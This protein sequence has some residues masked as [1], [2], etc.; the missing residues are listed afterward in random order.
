MRYQDFQFV[1]PNIQQ[2]VIGTQGEVARFIPYRMDTT[3]ESILQELRRQPH[4][5]QLTAHLDRGRQLYL[6]EGERPE[7]L[8]LA[9]EYIASYHR[10]A[11]TLSCH[12]DTGSDCED[13]DIEEDWQDGD[14]NFRDFDFSKSIPLLTLQQLQSFYSPDEGFGFG[15]QMYRPDMTPQK[16]PWWTLSQDSPLI[17]SLIDPDQEGIFFSSNLSPLPRMLRSVGERPL[18]IV[19]TVQTQTNS[20]LDSDMDWTSAFDGM[21]M[22]DVSFELETDCIRLESPD[23]ESRYKQD[24]LRQLA[25]ERKAPLVRGASALKILSLVEEHRGDM[26]NRTISKA[27]SNALLRR[28]AAGP[29]R[30]RDFAYLSSVFPRRQAQTA[31]EE[32]PSA[33]VGQEDIRRKLERVAD[34]MVFQKRR[35]ALGLPCSPI[36]YTF[37]F[38]GAPGTGKTSWAVWLTKEMTRRGLLRSSSFISINAAELKA[39]YVGHTTGKVKALFQQYNAIL[40]DEAYSLSEGDD[41]F[42]REALAQ[43]CIELEEHAEDRLVIFAGYGGSSDPADNRMLHFLQSNPGINSRVSFKVHFPSLQSEE[44]VLVLRSMLEREHYTLPEDFPALAEGFFQQRMGRRAFG[45][46]RE[47]RNLADRI[48]LQLAARLGDCSECGGE[49]LSGIQSQDIQRAAAEILEEYRLLEENGERRIG[50]LSPA[51]L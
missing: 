39:K 45:S 29:L 41:A 3:P 18:I 38:L 9:A 30:E 25:R 44:L 20:S 1:L 33:L 11:D 36:H 13:P 48:K 26:D 46:C 16:R 22:D 37:A 35:R 31:Q 50:F 21:S 43:L 28:K 40:L 24:I 23:Q 42:S 5:A 47:A 6:L 2:T 10:L 17:I 14:P 51:P 7:L 8:F 15:N 19:L 34:S 32:Q 4:M 49:T 27:V 12:W